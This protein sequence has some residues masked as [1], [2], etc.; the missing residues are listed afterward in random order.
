MEATRIAPSVRLS[1][2]ADLAVSCVDLVAAT[3]IPEARWDKFQIRYLCNED[4]YGISVKARQI[5][6]SWL[7]ALDAICDSLLV[8]DVPHIFI[9][10]NQSEADEKIRYANMILDAWHAPPD[11]PTPQIIR[12]NSKVIEF[13]NRS[14]IISFPCR[15]P[16]GP[17]K[18]RI[19]LDEIAHYKENMARGILAAALPGLSKGN[20]Y[21]RLGSSPLGASGIFWEI[22]T[23][24][25]REYP[26]Y[27]KNKSYI[28]WWEV[29]YFC[30][31]VKAARKLAP[32]MDT[33]TRVRMYGTPPLIEIF[34]N[35]FLEDF[36]Q[37]HE[38]MWVDETTAWITWDEIKRNQ[39]AF[40]ESK[41]FAANGVDDALHML[42]KVHK[43]IRERKI[44]GVLYGGVDIGR[45]RNTT[46]IFFVGKTTTG[47]LPLRVMITLDNVEFDDQ[48][49][50]IVR[51][52]KALPVA[53][54]LI[55]RN[56]I[57]MQLAE[58]VPKKARRGEG[59][60]YTNANKHLWSVEARAQA[61]RCNTPLPPDRDLA[62][63]IHS[64]KKLVTA[65][66]NVAYDTERNEKHHADKYWAWATAVWAANTSAHGVGVVI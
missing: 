61:Q 10:I 47:T 19:Y 12:S 42:P 29:Q 14:R 28:P 50:V 66:K 16:R 27:A 48:E 39:D 43:A 11:Y 57:G 49:D 24:S 8:R 63:Q 56:G 44:E 20:G 51:Y 3:G 2:K 45:T 53:N 60:D 54:I 62:Y 35:M 32:S 41:Y 38:C 36:Q 15:E 6:Y 40:G 18:Q 65:A 52:V 1:D 4:K 26:G 46:E 13:H 58:N 37:E 9:S 25:L 30:C 55:D 7:S 17:A 34:E 31:D 21:I 33:E 22:A 5:G 64:V 59:V 23:E